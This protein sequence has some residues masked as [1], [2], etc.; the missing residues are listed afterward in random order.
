MARSGLFRN[1][2]ELRAEPLSFYN[3][4]A[5]QIWNRLGGEIRWPDLL[6]VM[7]LHAVDDRR[8]MI[9]RLYTLRALYAPAPR[10][11]HV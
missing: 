5:V 7:A 3:A 4:Q 11:P 10:P 9:E 2:P 6:Y 8:L 1:V